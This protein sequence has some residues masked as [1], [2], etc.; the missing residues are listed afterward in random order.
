MELFQKFIDI[1]TDRR[2]LALNHNKPILFVALTL[3]LFIVVQVM[4][5]RGEPCSTKRRSKGPTR[6][7]AKKNGPK[8]YGAKRKGP[9][10]YGPKKYGPKRYGS[11]RDGP[12]KYGSKAKDYEE[13]SWEMYNALDI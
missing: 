7:G 11:K 2:P 9:K 4:E 5:K 13:H 1:G 10:R 3:Q 6:Y 12:K 8:R